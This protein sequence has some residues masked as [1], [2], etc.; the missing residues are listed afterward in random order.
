MDMVFDSVNGNT[1]R[2]MNGKV[3]RSAVTLNSKHI[4]FW[5]EAIKVFESMEFI[6]KRGKKSK[7]PCIKNW[8]VTLKALNSIW[9]RLSKDNFKYLILRNINQDPL[10]C[11]FGQFRQLS[12]RNINPDCFHFV[13]SFK[14]L[15]LNNFSS[16]KSKETNCQQNKIETLSN[17]K[18][19]LTNKI[20]N[21]EVKVN[22]NFCNMSTVIDIH[23][24]NDIND[25]T[26]SY[27]AG[28]I[29]KN[30]LTEIL[31]CNNCT[32]E[33]RSNVIT[34]PLIKVRQYNNVKHG[35]CNPSTK[36]FTFIKEILIICSN[37]ITDI[38]HE[39]NI[40][41]QL[42]LI[43]E[44]NTNI[45]FTCSYHET[46]T[47]LIKKTVYMF[48]FTYFKN[49][50]RILKGLDTK[51]NNNDKI[52]NMASIYYNRHSKRFKSKKPLG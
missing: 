34:N 31:K 19:F 24:S 2:S 6:D 23:K 40:A 32:S 39:H 13:N 4:S 49:I 7:P 30:K 46:K 50:N 1:V 12:G 33:L 14:T 43:I 28:F 16:I 38:F 42:I 51:H 21:I 17:L 45:I 37:S 41:Q 11:I 9:T 18:S 36:L 27:V 25:M 15:L 44:M 22:V 8:I 26:V 52:K 48:L 10:E 29:I 3:L 5:N 47:F 20:E 35:L